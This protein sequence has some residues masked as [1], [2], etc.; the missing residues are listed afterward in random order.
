MSKIEKFEDIQVWKKE[1][2]L[3]SDMCYE[4][5]DEYESNTGDM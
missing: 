4:I 2:R 1:E 3:E 5:E